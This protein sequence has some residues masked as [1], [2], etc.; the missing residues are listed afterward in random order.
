VDRRKAPLPAESRTNRRLIY[1]FYVIF[2][3]TDIVSSPDWR[4]TAA[5][6]GQIAEA[7]KAAITASKPSVVV[8]AGLDE[9]FFM[10]SY[11]EVHTLPA[12]KGPDG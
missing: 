9:S 8:I 10:A 5:Y 6:V 1:Y 12:A 7:A 2:K 4:L 11:E 3:K